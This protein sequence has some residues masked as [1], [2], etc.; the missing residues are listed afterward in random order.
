MEV[1][2]TYIFIQRSKLKKPKSPGNKLSKG[3]GINRKKTSKYDIESNIQNMI[4]KVIYK[5]L[6][7]YN[8]EEI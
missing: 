5:D 8:R 3:L 1:F 4:L 7:E 6:R 2:S